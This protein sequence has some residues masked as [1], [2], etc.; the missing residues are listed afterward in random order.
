M[1]KVR[2]KLDA[3]RRVYGELS[4]LEE[5]MNNFTMQ[6]NPECVFY[7]YFQELINPPFIYITYIERYMLNW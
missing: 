7:Q 6:P 4:S 1:I 3:K 5:T 2:H